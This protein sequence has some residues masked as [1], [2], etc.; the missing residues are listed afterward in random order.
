MI[1]NFYYLVRLFPAQ[2]VKRNAKSGFT[3]E[4]ECQHNEPVI[5]V[6][7]IYHVINIDAI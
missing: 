1:N 6:N 3:D 4:I 7:L 5:D 2:S